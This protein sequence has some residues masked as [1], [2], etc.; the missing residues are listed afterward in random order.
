MFYPPLLIC[1]SLHQINIF[2]WFSIENTEIKSLWVHAVQRNFS[3]TE[4]STRQVLHFLLTS[5]TKDTAEG[6]RHWKLKH[7]LPLAPCEADA[8]LWFNCG[9]SQVFVFSDKHS[10]SSLASWTC[11]LHPAVSLYLLEKTE[12][13][14]L[15]SSIQSYQPIVSRGRPGGRGKEQQPKLSR[16]S[17]SFQCNIKRTKTRRALPNE[18]TVTEVNTH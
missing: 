15:V 16:C 1:V 7:L 14:A 12:D 8:A 13:S 5:Q 17:R 9:G 6:C 18:G 3:V 10:F 2:Q 11:S 4:C